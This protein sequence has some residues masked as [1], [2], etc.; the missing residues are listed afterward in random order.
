MFP[1]IQTLQC[2]IVRRNGK[3]FLKMWVTIAHK[4]I[5]SYCYTRHY[6][7]DYYYNFVK[8]KILRFLFNSSVHV[9]WIMIRNTMHCTLWN[10]QQIPRHRELNSLLDI[11]YCNYTKGNLNIRILC[12]VTPHTSSIYSDQSSTTNMGLA[13]S[14]NMFVPIYGPIWCHI[15]DDCNVLSHWQE[16][17]SHPNHYSVYINQCVQ[18][19][20]GVYYHSN[21]F[22]IPALRVYY[23]SL[24]QF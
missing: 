3:R 4:Y 7:H 9:V 17:I 22:I 15:P 11:Y 20:I 24:T 23:V 5:N 2:Q 18:F 12:D 13:V 14:S 10:L 8:I 19:L 1:V 21:N 6:K 16:N